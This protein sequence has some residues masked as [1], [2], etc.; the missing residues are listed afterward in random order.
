[1]PKKGLYRKK[2]YSKSPET[3]PG[4]EIVTLK[5]ELRA[6]EEL[7]KVTE[8]KLIDKEKI[9][10]KLKDLK[11]KNAILEAEEKMKVK[12]LK[13][14]EKDNKLKEI[15]E[16]MKKLKKENLLLTEEIKDLK[17]QKE[18]LLTPNPKTPKDEPSFEHFFMN[19]NLFEKL[20]RQVLTFIAYFSSSD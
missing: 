17:D 6:K 14:K 19:K 1:M 15:E 16:K 5:A 10:E 12:A 20:I 11:K 8:A 9:E 3:D 13:L 4:E 7:L 18:A 2:G